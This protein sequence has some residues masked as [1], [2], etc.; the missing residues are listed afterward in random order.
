MTML[1]LHGGLVSFMIGILLS[2]PLAAVHYNQS[3]SWAGVFANPRKLKSA[4]L[5]FFMQAFAAGF[6]YMLERASGSA[7]PMFV[8]IPLMYGTIGNPL[9][10][11]LESIANYRAGLMGVFYRFLRATSPA[12][13]MLAWFMIAGKLLPVYAWVFLAVCT[14]AGT[15]LIW[16]YKRHNGNGEV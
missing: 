11:L 13:L 10:L 3:P 5:D 4:H 9:I 14:A 6:A 7:L 12:L 16:R 2:L 1:L 15:L 8:A